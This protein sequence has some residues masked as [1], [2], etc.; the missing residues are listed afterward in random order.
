MMLVIGFILNN[1]ITLSI[2]SDIRFYDKNSGFN[3]SLYIDKLNL[4]S[5]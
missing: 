1:F 4:M 3:S 5:T 2:D